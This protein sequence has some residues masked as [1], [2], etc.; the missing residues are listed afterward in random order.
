MGDIILVERERGIKEGDLIEALEASLEDY[1]PLK[2]V[3]LLPGY[4]EKVFLCRED[5][6]T[7]L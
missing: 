6:C 1:R 5:N 3:L 2:R 4:N 7:V